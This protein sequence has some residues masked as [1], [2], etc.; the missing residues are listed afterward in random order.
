MNKAKEQLMD[1][2]LQ[3]ESRVAFRHGL[4]EP[5]MAEWLQEQGYYGS[6][7]GSALAGRMLREFKA[8]QIG[9]RISCLGAI[10]A[11]VWLLL[12]TDRDKDKDQTAELINTVAF[13]IVF[14]IRDLADVDGTGLYQ[15]SMTIIDDTELDQADVMDY[16]DN[17]V[18]DL[19][20][21]ES[22]L[23]ELLSSPQQQPRAYYYGLIDLYRAL[24]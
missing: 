22:K 21:N 3:G 13:D 15:L 12:L 20:A 10:Q 23:L 7:Q 6:E 5:I 2:Y 9:Y 11:S 17:R 16:I 14:N 24:N 18:V 8:E 1:W 19:S 4:S